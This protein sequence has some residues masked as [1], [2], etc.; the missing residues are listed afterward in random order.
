M[1]LSL[2]ILALA[3][4]VQADDSPRVHVNIMVPALDIVHMADMLGAKETGNHWDGRPGSC[5][6]L[7]EHQIT[8]GVWHQHMGSRPFSDCR[9]VNLEYSCTLLHIR[10]LEDQISRH[11]LTVSP[12]TVATAWNHG[13]GYLYRHAHQHTA[14][15][16]EVSALYYA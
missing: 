8:E 9:I 5:G 2:A 4:V 16:V 12:E 13:L 14:Y 6:E 11:G 3:L 1:R 10:W 7:G 15:G